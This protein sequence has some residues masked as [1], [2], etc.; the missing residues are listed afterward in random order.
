M[1][2]R[3]VA[4]SVICLLFVGCGRVSPPPHAFAKHEL[5]GGRY[6][7]DCED[8]GGGSSLSFSSTSEGQVVKKELYDFSWGGTNQLRIE[9]GKLT[10]D[11]TE[12]GTLQRGD[13]ITI[14]AAGDVLVNG[15]KR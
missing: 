14:T 5:N 15:S 11:G 6:F 13:R 9:D 1:I 4:Y 10:V 2:R 8:T 7:I 3:V 12:R